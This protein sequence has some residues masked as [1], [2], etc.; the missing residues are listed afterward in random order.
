MSVWAQMS[1][2]AFLSG[3]LRGRNLP[4]AAF[5]WINPVGL[6]HRELIFGPGLG[7]SIIAAILL[8]DP[9]VADKGKWFKRGDHHATQNAG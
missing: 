8:L 7:S 2:R 1:R 6:V 5:E 3:T 9:H 4:L